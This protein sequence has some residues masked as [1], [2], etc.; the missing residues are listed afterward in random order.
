MRGKKQAKKRP[1]YL[2]TKYNST[3]IGELINK[4]LMDGKKEKAQKIVYSALEIIEV[5]SKKPALEVFEMAIRKASPEIEVKSKRIGGATYQ[6]PVEVS[7]GRKID[8]V[9]RWLIGTARSK[10]G[11]KM[12]NYLAEEIISM[13]SGEGSVIKKRD[14]VHK[15]AEA[16]KAFAHFARF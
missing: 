9:L 5:K 8:L 4:V 1:P 7:P 14:D 16:N 13:Y 15:M 11:K 3:L 6:V 12:D 10:Q 2:D